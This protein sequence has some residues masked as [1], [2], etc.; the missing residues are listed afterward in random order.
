MDKILNN[1]AVGSSV[2]KTYYDMVPEWQNNGARKNG[3][4]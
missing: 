3:R 1:T 2:D 4:Y